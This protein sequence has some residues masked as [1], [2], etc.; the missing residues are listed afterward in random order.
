[1]AAR[2]LLDLLSPAA[3]IDATTIDPPPIDGPC[4]DVA[5]IITAGADDDRPTTGADTA[6]A[7]DAARTYK[8]TG[9]SG[10]EGDEPSKDDGYQN[11]A[12]HCRVP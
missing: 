6:G 12:L 1:M 4:I 11:E 2:S 9:L 7:I 8:R 5:T 3:A 10:A